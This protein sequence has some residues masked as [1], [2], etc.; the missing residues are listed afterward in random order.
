MSAM[1]TELIPLP[2]LQGAESL[3]D[4]SPVKVEET[5]RGV[6]RRNRMPSEQAGIE[7][8]VDCE[9]DLVVEGECSLLITAVSNPISNTINYSPEATPASMI[10]VKEDN[11]T[12][13]IRVT[14][15]G[16]GISQAD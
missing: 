8:T 1:I 16:I 11:D 9:P 2:K 14:G 3:L 10:A 4:V 15:H 12:V 5:V 6:V 13:A 7:I